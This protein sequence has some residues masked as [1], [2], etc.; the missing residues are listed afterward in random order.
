MPRVA[1][2]RHRTQVNLITYP[3]NP[4]YPIG[5]GDWNEDP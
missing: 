5:T 2:G 4:N 3:D 1:Y